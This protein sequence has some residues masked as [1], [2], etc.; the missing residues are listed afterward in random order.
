MKPPYSRIG[1]GTVQF[2]IPYGINNSQGQ[3]AASQVSRILATAVERGITFLDTARA[4][5]TS[6]EVLGHALDDAGLREQ[7]TV[8][9]KLDLPAG[10]EDAAA[11]EIATATRN[12]IDASRQALGVDSLEIVLLHRPGYR[13]LGGGVVWDTL[14]GMVASGVIGEI[15]VSAAS[16]PSDLDEF[17]DDDA[18]TMIQI[19]F[20]PVDARWERE[21]V[22]D[23]VR[24]ATTLVNR[25]TFLQ[26]LLL[27]NDEAVNRRL[28]AA[29]EAHRSWLETCSELG[30][31][32][33]ELSLRY[34][35]SHPKIDIT[36]IGIDSLEQ[37]E[38][39]LDI[40]ALPP[41]DAETRIRIAER[42]GSTDVDV[43]NPSRW[44]K[45]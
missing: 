38:E 30:M 39:D 34:A 8:C 18:T 6:E 27:M 43:V 42:C 12:S 37:L 14:L 20:N 5:G 4:Y 45:E 26:G 24:E 16:G 23:S 7:C 25:S 13:T 19:P 22:F 21:A 2:G 35:A 29:I 9:T 28:P 44:P 41:L 11:D 36:L 10:I 31:K 32:P 33:V 17:V 40:A 15:G 1:L 3:V